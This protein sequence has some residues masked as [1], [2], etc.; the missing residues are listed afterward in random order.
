MFLGPNATANEDALSLFAPAVTEHGT[1]F[2]FMAVEC[3]RPNSRVVCA[4][5]GMSL[6]GGDFPYV[7]V[8][9]L[10][11]GR[12]RYAGSLH[13]LALHLRL[14]ALPGD[15]FAVRMVGTEGVL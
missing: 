3:D 11:G 13:E 6:T 9:T 5:A 14:R 2:A 12:E 8:R 7:F 1:L 4:K 15:D 10:E